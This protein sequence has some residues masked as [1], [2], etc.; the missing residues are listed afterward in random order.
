LPSL[1]MAPT[2]R[3]HVTRR[4][5]MTL[6]MILGLLTLA[7]R[8]CL[9]GIPPFEVWNQGSRP[10]LVLF[11]TATDENGKWMLLNDV[12]GDQDP[13]RPGASHDVMLNPCVTPFDIKAVYAKGLTQTFRHLK[14]CEGILVIKDP[15]RRSSHR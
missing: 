2:S 15:T 1:I 11:F 10:I 9:A 8:P 14:D 12:F 6:L 13:I 4:I 5:A 7:P 3:V